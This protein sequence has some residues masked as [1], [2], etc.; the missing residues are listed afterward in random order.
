MR[1][2]VVIPALNESACIERAVRSAWDAGFDEVVVV[3]GGSTDDTSRLAGDSGATVVYGPRGRAVQQNLGA[4]HASGDVLL[5]LHADNWLAPET[6]QQ[7]RDCLGDETVQAGA[8]RQKILSERVLFRV[9]ERGNAARAILR[10]MA[11]GDQGIFMRRETFDSLGGFPP[12]KLMEDLL[13]M[14]A[15]RKVGRLSVLPGPVYV[16]PRRWD[17]RGILRQTLTNWS[18]VCAEKMGVSPDGLARFYPAH[19]E[20]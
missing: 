14:R 10:G 11:Y 3:D 18:L 8:F 4:Q 19:E 17:K 2:S 16:H 5:F 7:V 1:I 13:L 12:V 15:F 9:L 20:E 6:G